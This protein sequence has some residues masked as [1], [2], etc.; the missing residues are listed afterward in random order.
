MVLPTWGAKFVDPVSFINC[1]IEGV[2]SFVLHGEVGCRVC[3][4]CVLWGDMG[5]L[6]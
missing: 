3:L 6:V 1:D 4:A 5:R 2:A